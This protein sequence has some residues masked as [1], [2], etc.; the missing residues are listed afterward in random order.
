M[1]FSLL[2]TLLKGECERRSRV[3]GA[4]KAAIEIQASSRNAN[5][6]SIDGQDVSRRLRIPNSSGVLM[7]S[8]YK[9]TDSH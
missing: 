2:F 1:S 5:T 4:S 3:A 7:R 8:L 9:E 6:N